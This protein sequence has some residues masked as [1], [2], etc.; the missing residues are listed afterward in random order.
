[1]KR[2]ENTGGNL[3]PK[4]AVPNDMKHAFDKVLR[5]DEMVD[6]LI[7]WSNINSGSYHVE[8]LNR[9]VE[10]AEEEFARLDG[11][12]EI[13]SLEPHKQVG[14]D[15][16]VFHRP[17]GNA[18]RIVKH[19][20]AP[21]RVFLCIHM[22]TVYDVYHPFQQATILDNNTIRGPGVIDAK[23]GMVVLLKALEVLETT[24]E[25][26]KIGW[27]LLIN[28]DEEI[29]SP[30]SAPLLEEAAERNHIGLLFEPCRDDG[31]LV[32]ARRGSG[33]YLAIA[34][35]R[36]A[37]AGRNPEDGRNAISGLCRFILG[38]EERHVRDDGIT[39]NV[40][41]IEG[42]GPVNVVPDRA[43]CRF[44]VRVETDEHRRRVEESLDSLTAQ[45]KEAGIEIKLHG[46]FARPPRPLDDRSK[47][48]FERFR[49]CGRDMGLELTLR[50]SG[51][52]CDGNNLAACG[53][54]VVD[55]LGVRGGQLHSSNE[56]ILTSSL[57]E[58]ARLT[59]LFLTRCARGHYPELTESKR[60]QALT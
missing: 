1:M 53:L 4:P 11:V 22:D 47:L 49:E 20:D 15:G 42:G 56:F 52:T 41:S 10:S 38:L 27:E 37:H 6:L 5:L 9:M 44:N 31:G 29:G 60:A 30:G 18:L 33:T 13:I 50:P 12:A 25:A 28:P 32:S 46:R 59:A 58:R 14:P 24:P 57:T 7:R 43:S 17:L 34:H 51:G 40:G 54:P 23:G 45:A 55:S 35:G 39:V 19:S 2:R 16:S 8:G 36:A 3:L 21:F 48:L 26:G